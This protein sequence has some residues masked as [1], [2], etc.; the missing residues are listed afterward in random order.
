M[1]SSVF[2]T[3]M[4][5]KPGK[6]MLMKLER[7]VKAAGMEQIDFK[8]KFVAI[9]V[10]FG[11]PGNLAYIR[12]DYVAVIVDIVKKLG[13][14]PFLT[15]ANTLYYGKRSNAVDHLDTA[16]KHGF[17]PLSTG[18]NVVIADGI[19]GTDVANVE[20]NGK[21]IKEAKIGTAIMD[22]DI[23]ISISHFK[24]HEQAGFG[25]A[26]KNIGMGS[27]SRAGK[28]EMHSSA[29]PVIRYNRCIGC[30]MCVK[31]CNYGAITLD[32]L[33][34]A[35]IDYDSCVGCGQCVAYCAYGSAVSG[36][37][38][39]AD[40]F[41]EKISEY[42]LAVVKNRPSFHIN[43]IVDVSPNC[44]C[45]SSN[46]RPIVPNIGI[47]AS[48]DPVGLDMACAD[49]VNQAPGIQYSSVHE[50]DCEY[51][52]GNDKFGHIHHNTNWKAGLIHGEAI[53]LGS[54]TYQM[55]KLD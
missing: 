54:I 12:A 11:E 40:K 13:G 9:K 43:F 39:E 19:R 46:D 45:W 53:G 55:I 26:V 41:V 29:Q 50:T 42:A 51:A 32:D 47:A 15:D 7:L 6:N 25:G 8:D 31:H 35:V 1:S 38:E 2:F 18:A 28:L 37:P 49:L 14:K 30:N 21:H 52:I 34:K 22:A 4:K 3:D 48:F 36:S 10:H 5:T 23:F 44:D 33:R 16:S 20:I 27:A 24:G 17:N